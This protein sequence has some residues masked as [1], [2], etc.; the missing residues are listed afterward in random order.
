[1][2]AYGTGGLWPHIQTEFAVIP[3]SATISAYLERNLGDRFAGTRIEVINA[4]I[5]STWT[6]H[7]LI[8]LNQTIL[9]Y[10]P[11]MVLFLDG[12]NDFYHFDP[13]HD[14]F[15][16]YA[17]SE[18]STVI[19]GPPSLRALVYGNA[20]WLSRKSAFA[21]TAFRGAQTLGRLIRGKPQEDPIDVEQAL[22]G[23]AETFPANALSMI[24]RTALILRHEEVRG[25]FMIQPMLLLEEQSELVPLEQELFEFNVESYLPNYED[26]IVRAVPLVSAMEEEAVTQL[27]GHF[28]D[29]TSIY[30]GIDGQVYTDYTHL[31]PLGNRV[32]ADRVADEIAPLIAKDLGGWVEDVTGTASDDTPG[33]NE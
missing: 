23:V 2:T 4:A 20:W 14:E 32:L 18:H 15:A 21:Y 7:H 31:T 29:L 11:D 1:S 33:L 19:M 26:F 22:R 27:G 13:G 8:Y 24:E 6:H 10:D 5:A 9:R 28:M 17:Y 3:D 16:S 25:V 12:F 30:A